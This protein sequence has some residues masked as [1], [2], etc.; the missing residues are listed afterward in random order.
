M[1]TKR[2]RLQKTDEHYISTNSERQKRIRY[3]GADQNADTGG[4]VTE[5]DAYLV[6]GSK[7]YLW[8]RIVYQRSKDSKQSYRYNR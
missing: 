6:I 5:D 8:K 1:K 7:F 3:L 4:Y 2:K